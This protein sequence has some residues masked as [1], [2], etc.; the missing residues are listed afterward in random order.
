MIA[1]KGGLNLAENNFI[2]ELI[3][4]L[5]KSASKKQVQTDAKNLGKIKIP[6]IGTLNKRQTKQQIK[7]DLASLNGTV[8]ITG[9][10]DKNGVVKSVQ[11]ATQQAQ[12]N[13]KA[14]PIEINFSVKKDKL[15][16]D[17]KLLGK[18]NSRLFKDTGMASKYNTLLD[19]AQLATSTQELN[20][21]RIQLGAFR[22]EIKVAGKAGMTFIDALKSGLSKVLQLFGGYNI[23]MQFTRQLRNAWKE[24]KELD[25][26]PT[27]LSRVNGE[28]SRSD[29]PNY[30]DK[31][32][33]KT[34][35]LSVATKD[36][37]DAVTTFSRAGYNLADSET[38]A[39][40]A[41]QLEKV[42]DMDSESASKALLAGLQGYTEI[43]GYGIEQLAEKAQALNDKIDIIGNT[44]SITQK[45]VA[46][47][48]QAV[49]S[50]MSDA[51]TSVD[52]FISLLG[53]GNRAVQD[54]NKVA[55]AIRTSALRIRGCTVELQE[56]GEETDDVIESTST[57][58][59]KIKALTNIDGSGGVNILEADEETF[60]SIYDIYNDIAK[61]YDKMSDKDASALLDLIAGKNRS[62][63]ISAI[64]NNM[65]EANELLDRSL[66]AAGT[67]SDEYQIYLDSAEATTE[68]F[69]VAMTET[70]NN[71][72]N[73]ETIKSLADAG[74]AVLNF[75]NSFGI[76]E[77]TIKGF[78]ALGLLKGIT[79]LTVAFK[80]SAVQVSN[81]GV[82]LSTVNQ[83]DTVRNTQKYA[84]SMN[85]LKV[86]CANLTS[87]Q[88]KQV[89]SNKALSNTERVKILRYQGLTKAQA[90]AKLAQMGLTQTT[91]AQTAANGAATASTFSLKA[92]VTGLGASIKA[93]FL[94]NP[95][96]IAIM[97][98]STAIGFATSAISKHNQAVE[99]ARQKALELTNSYKEQKDSLDSQIEKYKELKETLDNGNLSTNETRFIKEQLL[100]IQKSLIDSYGN[101]ASN[102]DL[103]NGK[104]KEQL[105]LLS[106]LSKEK[107]TDYV[108][109]NRDV[110]EDA[111]EEL[112]KVRTYTI[113]GIA[114]WNTLVPK[115]EDQQALLDFIESYSELFDITADGSSNYAS[116]QFDVRNLV[117]KAD[118][119][120]ADEIMRQFYDD[121]DQFGKDNSIDV[122][123]ILEGISG[124]LKKTTAD[125][126]KE[127]GSIYDEFM[128]AEIVRNDTLRPLYQQS[129]QAVEDYNEALSSGEGV[130]EAK[131]NL[132]TVQQSVQNATGELEGSQKVFD[133]IYNGINKNAES[134]YNLAQSFE[135]NES[136]KE[137]AE[138][139][140]GL[141]DIDLQAINFEDNVQSPGEE[142]FG[143]LIDILGISE[144][145]VQSLID[146]LV[147]L[148]Y[149]QGKVQNLDLDL[150]SSIS[151]FE[152]AWADSFT[153]EN[154]K[155][156]ELGDTLLDLAEKGRLTKE[157]FKEADSTAGDYF[158]NL[159]IS[160]D[161]AVSKINK[162][163]DESKQLSSMSDQISSMAE[164]LG[165]KLEDGFVSAD[166]LSGFD[167]E[168]RGL[169]S[170]DRFQEVLGSTASSYE[171]CQEAANALATEWINSSDFLSQL[172][173][174]NEDYYKTQLK[175]M[176][177]ENY[178]EVISY[179]HDLNAAKE[180]LMQ[181][182]LEL[183][184]A[185]YDE[186]EALIEEG[187]YSELTANMILALYDA[188][189]AEQAVTLDTAADCENLIA[190]A[191]DTDRT[192][193]SIQLLI[194]LMNIYNQ[195]E[196]GAY[197][198]NAVVRGGALAAAVAIKSQLEALAN[199]EV[200][201]MEI[202]PTVKLGSKGKSDAKKSGK[203]AA[204]KYLEAF[205]K[206]LEKLQG[207][208]DRN[209][210]T[211]KEYL[212]NLRALYEKYFKDREKYIDEFEKY[213]QEYLEGMESLYKDVMNGIIKLVDK[214]ADKYEEMKDSAV[215]SYNAQKDAA[216]DAY[217][218]QIEGIEAQ[219]DGINDMI[220]AIDAEIEAKKKQADAI[221]E[222][223]DRIKEARE[224]RQRQLD[225]QK[226]QYEF[227]RMMNQRS[228]LQYSEEKGMHYVADTSGARDKK[229]EIDEIKEE[230]YISGL[231][232]QIDLINDEIDLLEERKD[233]FEDQIDGLEK[234]KDA[235]EKM[236]D[237]SNDYF[238]SMI[239]Q[240]ETYYDK[241][242]ESLDKTKSRWEELADLKEEAEM[243]GKMEE[244]LS[245]YG[246]TADDVVNMSE[247]TFQAFKNDYLA[248]L[249]DLYSGN[250]QMQSAI[251]ETAGTTTD[252]LESYIAKTQEYIDS[253]ISMDMSDTA[254]SM[255]N[256]AESMDKLSTATS[257]ANENTKAMS[258]NMGT[259]STNTAEL[260]ENATAVSD[261]LSSIP[262]AE[263]FNVLTTSFTNLA[264][265]IKSV[266]DALGVSGNGT[267][268]SLVDTLQSL[269]T[270]SIDADGN[271][272]I[273]QF[274][275]LKTAIEG[276]TSAISG[277]GMS[278]G[279]AGEGSPS[280]SPSMSAGAGGKGSA[281][282]GLISA[283]ESIKTATD[284]AL[285]TGGGEDGE[286]GGTGAIGQFEQLKDA[287]DDVTASIGGGG[288]SESGQGS[289]GSEGDNADS[290]IGSIVDL[291]DTTEEILTGGGESEGESGGVIG[292]FEEFSD[293]IEEAKDHVMGIS[294]GLDE[295]DGKEVECTIRVNIETNGSLPAFAEGTLGDTNLESGEY[296]AKYGKAFAEGTG[297]YK[298]LPKAE[299]N[300][301]V[302]EY[303]QTEMTVLPN[304]DT[305][306]TDEPTMM[307]L[308]KDTVIFNEEQ[309]KKIM[310]NKVHVDGGANT[311]SN[312]DVVQPNG[313]ILKPDG[314]VIKPNGV[315]IQSDGTIITPEGKVYE[316]L[317][318][319]DR[320]Y[321]M[322]QKFNAYFNSVAPHFF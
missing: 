174:Q 6:L 67:A 135:N 105:G 172:T 208:R 100:E 125:E 40:M 312:G 242:I 183:G 7:Q 273:T 110:F 254:T 228:I 33:N 133:D 27:D 58:A 146:K 279:S 220:D 302:S 109:E 112:E 87:A 49:G 170:W 55:L 204:D 88:L 236:K 311:S 199:G 52:E 147:E 292:R 54:S 65:S 74:T 214:Q 15:I 309:T 197:E 288:S 315:A 85:T 301:L 47:G 298:G 274:N 245:Q 318:P 212:D 81:Y 115:T 117:I 303:G 12:K 165:T 120:S 151:T 198:N 59:A 257:D 93:A 217:D 221:Q 282:G 61:V 271:G 222:E 103:V 167:V 163:V 203:K 5:N 189:I 156:K 51:N 126:F 143:A 155:V 86:S 63:Q 84:K 190:L 285:G 186:I 128:K 235:I 157:A 269:S 160:A 261:A 144:E 140:R 122:S 294:E 248:M 296:T 297:K 36:Y 136:V 26:A 102:I 250:E 78:L 316:P 66:N 268:N 266:A 79:T 246:V 317:R 46:S 2:I 310:D 68:R 20:N 291:G 101:E 277:G 262:D 230:M 4:R 306:I 319:G 152:D 308:P 249:S 119:E 154:D 173:E 166:T 299:K 205:E 267:V 272:L 22:S 131:A 138:Q 14:K 92:A 127:Y 215:D 35:E 31:V 176:G 18:Q 32:I 43:D 241:L 320:M 210:I 8:K 73:G 307:D 24:A 289:G 321:D 213:E 231:E 247:E 129:I 194:Q 286:G 71:I 195:L 238:E 252:Q 201:N 96:G 70:Y 38:L 169:E 130:A 188:K 161:E 139:L 264:E 258:E 1:Q 83:L 185:T 259:L 118:V 182:S 229:E 243:K 275:N 253:L 175:A 192:S 187:T 29:F 69:G 265:A 237:A 234:Q 281:V 3:A 104:Y 164:A 224:E 184:D 124:Q 227:Q 82:A 62:N 134:A 28:I 305:I 162:L 200:K 168:V 293:V 304:G 75:A 178:D 314:T 223:I 34:K 270:I 177:I 278:G 216:E 211:E 284:E 50:V 150:D 11:Q 300:A 180:V 207:M 251:A 179:A 116:G 225:L 181:S 90:Q 37:I 60:R 153:S 206:E 255:D 45:E 56:M 19:N 283:V 97:A 72:L 113:N 196:S 149:V 108:A 106:E 202:E 244:I 219:I 39:D 280:S 142:A 226:A 89:L 232:K 111:K 256:T 191:G 158:K 159:G 76:V 218:A 13:T 17:I 287:V 80:N 123:G 98:I 121:L 171:E 193:Q 94:S 10:V 25:S 107:A 295:I 21:L 132:D 141:T 48:I 53:A 240:T 263:K 95:V 30:L 114:S 23:V 233:A 148:G 57:L 290:L 9:K 42:G 313:D 16:N 91:N 239:K 99:E 77:G 41:M 64:L 276:V 145:E 260:G 209:E 44:A 137:F 322:L